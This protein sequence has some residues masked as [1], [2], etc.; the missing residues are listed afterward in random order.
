M[1]NMNAK[2]F[3]FIFLQICTRDIWS[4]R[5]KFRKVRNPKLKMSPK[6]TLY[7]FAF[8]TLFLE[9]SPCDEKFERAGYSHR[10]R[11]RCL[12]TKVGLGIHVCDKVFYICNICLAPSRG[13]IF[14]VSLH[15]FPSRSHNFLIWILINPA[16]TLIKR[17][18]GL[19]VY[20]FTAQTFPMNEW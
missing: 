10:T 18:L 1:D 9:R 8:N 17:T 15:L 6:D 2:S 13:W 5:P 14:S 19:L 7:L 3:P 12:H 4:W 16:G 20:C 11:I